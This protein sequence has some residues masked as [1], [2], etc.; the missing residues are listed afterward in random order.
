MSP[1]TLPVGVPDMI[2]A[3]YPSESRAH[4]LL[5]FVFNITMSM[6][7]TFQNLCPAPARYRSVPAPQPGGGKQMICYSEK[8]RLSAVLG[9]NS[10]SKGS[11]FQF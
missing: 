2:Q 3:E 11:C 5:P 4:L 7:P 10:T 8:V 1:T 9:T 6:F